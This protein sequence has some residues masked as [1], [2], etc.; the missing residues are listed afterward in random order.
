MQI[1]KYRWSLVLAAIHLAAVIVVFLRQSADAQ[2]QLAYLAFQVTDFPVSQVYRFLPAPFAEA[3][4]GT[5][6][7]FALPLGVRYLWCAYRHDSHPAA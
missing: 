7:W 3:F 2:W 1:P 5:A 4:V 6:W